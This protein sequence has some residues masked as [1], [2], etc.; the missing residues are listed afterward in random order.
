MKTEQ[1]I[2]T[3]ILDWLTWHGHEAYKIVTG[4]KAG[5]PDIV[6]CLKPFGRFLVVEVKRPNGKVTPL[7]EYRI[8]RINM[9]GGLGVVATSVDDVKE[10]LKNNNIILDK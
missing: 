5:I 6:A 9:T 7:Q 10:Y 8:K 1:Q 3:D 2:Q 4:N